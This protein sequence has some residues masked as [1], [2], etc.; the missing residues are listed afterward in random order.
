MAETKVE[1]IEN[2]LVVWNPQEGSQLYKTGLYD[3]NPKG[4]KV[5]THF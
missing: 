1:L 5:E 3:P 4:P 2:F